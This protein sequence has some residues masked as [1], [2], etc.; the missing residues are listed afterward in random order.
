MKLI[1]F[2]ELLLPLYQNIRDNDF[3]V[4]FCIREFSGIFWI[5]LGRDV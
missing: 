1:D 4:R 3:F 5:L 2:M